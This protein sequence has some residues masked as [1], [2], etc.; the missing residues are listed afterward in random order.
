M[1]TEEV[2]IKP[3]QDWS[4]ILLWVSI[5]LAILT[6]AAYV[7]K[8]L[9]DRHEKEL[10][11]RQNSVAIQQAMQDASEARTELSSL[12]QKNAPRH[13]SEKQR[14]AMMPILTNLRGHKIAFVG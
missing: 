7:A 2:M 5:M 14:G 8:S 6:A 9:V 3:L 11:G 4:Q 1:P 12:K 13:L 10:S